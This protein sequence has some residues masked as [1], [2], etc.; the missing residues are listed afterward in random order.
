MM[1]DTGYGCCYHDVEKMLRS[2]GID[3]FTHVR[4]V[5]CTHAD[6]G[7]CGAAGFLPVPSLM[8]PGTKQ[9]LDAGT[10]GFGS[11]THNE[12]L[13]RAYTT[14]INTFSKMNVS[15]AVE[16]YKTEPKEMHGLFPVID[17]LEVGSMHF[18]IW[19][20]LGGHIAG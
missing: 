8:H 9:I 5:T 13:E 16:L 3:G 10:R 4:K 7:H 12:D 6:A 19:E 2:L 20:S 18:E 11:D 17:K 1:L 15:A 14:T